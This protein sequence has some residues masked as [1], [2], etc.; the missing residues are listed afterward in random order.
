MMRV[1]QI[2]Q[3][4]QLRGAEIFACQL[5][6][7]L[8]LSGVT[9]DV[10]FLFPGEDKL[11]SKFPTLRFISLHANRQKR[12]WD[13]D[14]YRRL[15]EIIIEGRY[16]IVQANAGDTLKYGVLS[17]MIHRWRAKLVFR[18]ASQMSLFIRKPWQRVLNQWLLKKCDFIISVSE[19]C[20]QDLIAFYPPAAT[21]SETITIGT[22]T[23]RDILPYSHEKREDIVLINMGS[24]VPEKNHTFLLTL[25]HAF[26]QKHPGSKL[27]LVGDGPLRKELEHRA[28]ALG[29]KD[30]VIFWGYR[31]DN[32]ALLKAADVMVMPSKI[33]G[34][35]GVILE[36]MITGVPV[37]ASAV[38]GIPEIIKTGETG[39]VISSFRVDDYM[40]ALESVLFDKVKR[41]LITTNS[42]QLM[43]E[44][45][46]LP[47]IATKFKR[48]YE[49]LLS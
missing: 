19:N 35:P 26:H 8:M 5:S 15:S 41:A 16:D 36:A 43:K 47:S 27:W 32:I 40:H 6:T 28:E 37:I 39:F 42:E 25:M 45:F 38:G 48:R 31:S 22:Y 34:L 1:L 13:L 24:F 33:E 12:F 46:T 17:K 23:F 44:Q 4:Q 3:K 29:L 9:V 2:I 18:N 10:V 7:E 14:A 30:S 11:S 20:R 49:Q 21:R